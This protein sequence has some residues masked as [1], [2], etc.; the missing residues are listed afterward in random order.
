MEA[1]VIT[2]R[3]GIEAALVIGIIL[4]Y[5]RKTGRVALN[6]Y[7]FIGLAG[8][9]LASLGVGVLFQ[10]LGLDPENEMLEGIMMGVAG[11]FVASMVVWMW[12]TA[13]GIKQQMENRLQGIVAN[14]AAIGLG[15]GLGLLLFTFVMVFREGIETVIFLSAL[16]I[17]E[18]ASPVNFLGGA[19]GLGMAILFAVLFVR[20]SLR[21]NLSR[22]FNVTSIVLLVLA[23]KF[24][25][26]SAHEFGELKIL[27]LNRELMAVLGYLLRENSASVVVSALIAV[28]I[29]LLLW[30][31]LRAKEPS[32]TTGQEG[33]VERRKRM[34]AA[35]LERT[36]QIVLAIA[37]VFIV[38]AL[39]STAFA[40]SKMVDLQPTP[41][42][43]SDDEVRMPTAGMEP[44]SVH[45]Y[46]FTTS[47][48]VE[49][50]FLLAKLQDGSVVGGLDACDICGPKGFGQ[51]QD[52]GKV[53]AICKNCN[54]PI[55]PDTFGFGGGCNPLPLGTKAGSANVTVSTA[56]LEAA[57]VKFQ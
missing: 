49:T 33:S 30:E 24:L 54:A 10:I 45:K 48:G 29:F 16:S 57:A 20:G 55:S 25:A 4:A 7:V 27:P 32:P 12:R 31:S 3:E 50:R 2:L 34:A 11:L 14:D 1:L 40:E 52:E 17:G 43:S 19:V 44:G 28:P 26:A 51:E 35:R 42:T 39:A 22:F 53:V 36:W 18:K 46:S 56:E 8:A 5:L 23:F 13:K 38:L 37:T 47:R 9:V 6:R 15:A 21:I 41:V